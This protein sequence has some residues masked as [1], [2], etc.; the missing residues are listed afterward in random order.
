MMP[1]Y[2]HYVCNMVDESLALFDWK[3]R[4]EECSSKVNRELVKRNQPSSSGRFVLAILSPNTFI[5]NGNELSNC[6]GLSLIV[7]K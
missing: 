4:E 7:N 5:R 2:V 1:C 3:Q 6:I